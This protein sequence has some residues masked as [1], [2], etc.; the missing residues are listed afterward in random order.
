[1]LRQNKLTLDLSKARKKMIDGN[2]HTMPIHGPAH[3]ESSECWCEP[4]LTA[5]Y[6]SEGGA[7][8]YLHKE[9]Q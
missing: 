5:D 9:I 7:K 6:S 2:V 1:M 8:A 4:E 3:I